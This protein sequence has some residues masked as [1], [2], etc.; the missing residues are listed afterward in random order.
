MDV[1]GCSA[2]FSESQLQLFLDRKTYQ[3]F[4]RLRTDNEIRKVIAISLS[5]LILGRYRRPSLLSLLSLRRDPRQPQRHR[6]RMSQLSNQK[7]SHLSHQITSRTNVS[8]FP[9]SPPSPSLHTITQID[10]NFQKS[11]P[12]RH[13]IP[14]K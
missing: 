5:K 7:L 1:S 14:A 9:P 3:R 4:D 12:K 2:S 8:R 10:S 11:K 13:V 6:I